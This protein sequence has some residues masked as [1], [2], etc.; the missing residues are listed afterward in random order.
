M[1]IMRPSSGFRG[2]IAA[3]AITGGIVAITLSRF[4]LVYGDLQNRRKL[5]E[6]PWRLHR[7]SRMP[8]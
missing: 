3:V 7:D 5:S 4:E 2:P 6:Q 8:P 1:P